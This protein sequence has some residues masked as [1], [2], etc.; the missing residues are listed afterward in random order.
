[1]RQLTEAEMEPSGQALM[2]RATK[3]MNR[4]GVL[5]MAKRIQVGSFI[6]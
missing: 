3:V 1:M 4:R 6:I 2:R 5:D